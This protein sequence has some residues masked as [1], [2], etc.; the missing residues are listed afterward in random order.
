MPRVAVNKYR[1]IVN[2]LYA[3]LIG[4]MKVKGYTQERLGEELGLTQQV[5]SSKLRKQQLTTL[6]LIQIIDILEIDV[7]RIIGGK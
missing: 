3:Y 1:Y 5:I 4:Q 7:T 2:D 6:E